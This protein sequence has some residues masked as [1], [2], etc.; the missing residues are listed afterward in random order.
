[1]RLSTWDES[2]TSVDTVM[3]LRPSSRTLSATSS[4]GPRRRDAIARSAPARAIASDISR[5]R[6][7]PP[8]VMTMDLPSRLS[9]SSIAS[10]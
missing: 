4:I 10:S 3:A 7:V 8:P 1:M 2:V 6:P 9:F 5:P